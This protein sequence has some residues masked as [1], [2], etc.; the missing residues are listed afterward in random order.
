MMVKPVQRLPKY[1]LLLKDLLKHTEE[2]HIDYENIK[3]CISRFE[4]VNEENNSNMNKYIHQCKLS[5]LDK[6]IVQP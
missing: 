2:G 6:L 3:S 5:E 4:H 1:I